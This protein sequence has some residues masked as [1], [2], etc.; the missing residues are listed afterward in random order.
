MSF[1][2]FTLLN[3]KRAVTG[4]ATLF[5]SIVLP[6]LLYILF[7]ELQTKRNA[8]LAHGN[9]AAYVMIAMA[10]FGGITAACGTVGTYT[11]ERSTGWGRQLALTPMRAQK[12]LFSQSIIIIFRAFLPVLAVFLVGGL[13]T[14]KMEP[15]AW[16][17]SFFIC[18]GVSLPFGL[19]AI[20]VAQL[21]RSE[22]AIGV[23]ASVLPLF[24]FAGNVFMPLPQD[25]LSFAYF[26]P[27]YG[28]VALAREPLTDGVQA[29]G[30]A[31]YLI[32]TPL[33]YAVANFTAWTIIF[34]VL[35]L[36]LSRRQKGR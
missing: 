32:E 13:N 28:S 36:L 35:C 26:T 3:L 24:A 1:T 18:V 9:A 2:T 7:G 4:Y 11:V 27:M 8:E 30:T 20:I 6:V 29:I 5:F 10:A 33:W 25:L 21:F 17:A 19:Y 31:P 16:I 22:A 34:A 14:A 23:A 15:T 12:Q